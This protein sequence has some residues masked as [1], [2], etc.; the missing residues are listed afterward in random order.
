MMK[1]MTGGGMK[2]AMGMMKN[3]KNKQGMMRK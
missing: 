3:M 2:K 1:M